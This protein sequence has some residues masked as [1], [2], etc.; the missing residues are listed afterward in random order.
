[1]SFQRTSSSNL[2]V[3]PDLGQSL[4]RFEQHA[5]FLQSNLNGSSN[6]YNFHDEITKTTIDFAND[7][8]SFVQLQIKDGDDNKIAF[9]VWLLIIFAGILGIYAILIAAFFWQ[10]Q[11]AVKRSKENSDDRLQA[12]SRLTFVATSPEEEERN[13]NQSGYEQVFLGRVV[14]YY[15]IFICLYGKIWMGL[16][17]IDEYTAFIGWRKIHEIFG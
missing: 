1:M 6:F 10:R 16:L 14:W 3:S 8:S 5:S 11:F 9:W 15:T 7:A 2:P 13:F 17:C 4:N 12:E